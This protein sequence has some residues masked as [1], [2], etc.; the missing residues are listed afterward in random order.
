MG[1]SFFEKTDKSGMVKVKNT[2]LVP[3]IFCT[4][5]CHKKQAK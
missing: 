4:V 1:Y 3:C 2:N 5:E